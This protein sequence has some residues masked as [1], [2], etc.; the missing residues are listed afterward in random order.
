VRSSGAVEAASLLQQAFERIPQGLAIIGT[1]GEVLNWNGTARALLDPDALSGCDERS[2]CRLFDCAAHGECIT[3]AARRSSVPVGR[4]VHPLGGDHAVVLTAETLD[5]AAGAV[6]VVVAP[7]ASVVRTAETVLAVRA[8]GVTGVQVAGRSVDGPWLRQ[9][10]G[11]LLRLFVAFRGRVLNV[12]EITEHL[13]PDGRRALA[14]T[15]RHL[16]HALRDHLEPERSR[17][18]R[19]S[20]VPSVGSGYTLDLA[21]TSIDADNFV[22]QAA[23][24]LDA[25]DDRFPQAENELT[26]AWAAY[27]GDFLEDA[28]YATWALRERERLRETAGKVLRALAD[29]A[30]MRE[31]TESALARMTA[32]AELEPF[33]NDVHR[34]IIGACLAG[35]RRTRA[36]R[37]FRAFRLRLLRAFGEEPDFGIEDARMREPTRLTRRSSAA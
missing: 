25:F 34:V 33:D 4:R 35:G 17:G 10:P 23:L 18:A 21:R 19:S 31:D 8:L 5:G 14:G 2:C 30:M 22:R 15:V 26:R 9:R 11:E 6:L 13:W 7:F 29:L 37:E 27:G 36:V 20:L 24:A 12:E 28:P 3:A 32:L 1:R 16:V